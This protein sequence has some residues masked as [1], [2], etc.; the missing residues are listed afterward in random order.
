MNTGHSRLEPRFD[1]LIFVL[2]AGSRIQPKESELLSDGK[3]EPAAVVPACHT[4]PPVAAGQGR[5]IDQF[6]PD[7]EWSYHHD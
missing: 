1:A 3:E 6:R 2:A 5:A 7:L 4:N